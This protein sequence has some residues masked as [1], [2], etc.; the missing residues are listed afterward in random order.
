VTPEELAGL[1][2]TPA[3]DLPPGLTTADLAVVAALRHVR[4]SLRAAPDEP[5]PADVV[6]RLDAALAEAAARPAGTPDPGTPDPATPEP[7]TP[8]PATP[9]P[10]SPPAPSPT[11][12]APHG[13]A[14]TTLPTRRAGPPRWLVPAAAAVVVAAGAGGGVALLRSDGGVT[15]PAGSPTSGGAQG[16]A[17]TGASGARAVTVARSGAAYT[18]A[19]QL[20]DGVRALLAGRFAAAPAGV[21]ASVRAAAALPPAVTDRAAGVPAPDPQAASAAA[22]ASA[23]TAAAGSLA[24]SAAA[25][26]SLAPGA[27]SP[28]ISGP[29]ATA[30][31]PDLA[32]CLRRLD[33]TDALLAV[34]SVTLAGRASLLVVFAGARPGQVAAYVVGPDCDAAGPSGL[35]TVRFVDVPG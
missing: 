10:A 29:P 22:S 25:A 4:A 35:R 9:E 34:D 12:I 20:D 11:P 21:V 3:A 5:M 15:S 8:E 30:F 13:A 17:A 19:D 28:R 7:A 16:G 23:P 1:A 31:P 33:P 14:V 6:A 24:G 32:A 2:D 26:G 18:A 27:P